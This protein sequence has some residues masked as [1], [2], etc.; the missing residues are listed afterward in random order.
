MRSKNENRNNG[1]QNHENQ[2]ENWMAAFRARNLGDVY[3]LQVSVVE[4]DKTVKH[5]KELVDCPKGEVGTWYAHNLLCRL[6]NEAIKGTKLEAY[7]WR[8]VR[9]MGVAGAGKNYLY[10]KVKDSENYVKAE[11]ELV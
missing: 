4:N 7:P 5:I 1:N 9:R 11:M 2:N 3:N 10:R 6:A 8:E